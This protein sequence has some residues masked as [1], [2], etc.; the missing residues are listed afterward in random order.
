MADPIWLSITYTN[1]KEYIDWFRRPWVY[2]PQQAKATDI[3]NPTIWYLQRLTASI[4]FGCNDS[5][6]VYWKE[7]LFLL[8]CALS[9][10]HVD[11]GA[12]VLPHL[13]EVAK[14]THGNVTSVGP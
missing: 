7:E 14:T 9:S 8:W 10:T 5:Q 1:R 12:F 4:I 6:N 11:I 3:Y 2:D 13:T